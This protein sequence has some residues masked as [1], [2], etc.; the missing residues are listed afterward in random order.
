M[1]IYSSQPKVLGKYE[2]GINGIL[3]VPRKALIKTLF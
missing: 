3:P 1:D 2:N